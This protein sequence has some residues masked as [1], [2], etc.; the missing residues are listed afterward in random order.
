L[1]DFLFVCFIRVN[2]GLRYFFTKG[3]DYSWKIW[4]LVFPLTNLYIIWAYAPRDY[5][6][7]TSVFYYRDIC[8]PIL[9]AVLF[10]IV[11]KWKRPRYSLTDE[12]ITKMWYIFVLMN[13][14]NNLY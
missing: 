12:W 4:R 8:S 14:T 1:F 7:E 13:N 5:C 9:V 10:I 11:R 6:T 3:S 2:L